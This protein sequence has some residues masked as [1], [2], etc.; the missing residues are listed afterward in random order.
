LPSSPSTAP[1]NLKREFAAAQVDAPWLDGLPASAYLEGATLHIPDLARLKEEASRRPSRHG[2][3]RSMMTATRSI[4]RC[5]RGSSI[6]AIGSTDSS[7][8][9]SPRHRLPRSRAEADMGDDSFHVLVMDLH[10]ALNRLTAEFSN[11]AIDGA[12]VWQLSAADRPL[13]AAFMRGLNRTRA[14]KLNHPRS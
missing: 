8:A 6:G 5:W 1:P 12:H 4:A 13:V 9:R 11:E 10:K 3:A 14:L 2:A 7:Q